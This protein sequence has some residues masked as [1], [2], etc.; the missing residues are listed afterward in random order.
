VLAFRPGITPTH[1]PDKTEILALLSAGVTT[2]IG[3]VNLSDETDVLEFAKVESGRLPFNIG[4]VGD[5]S[6]LNGRD[7][8]ADLDLL[9]RGIGHGLLAIVKE[10]L[11]ADLVIHCERL[12]VPLIPRAE[13]SRYSDIAKERSVL[14]NPMDTH[15]M[16][17]QLGLENRGVIRIGAVA[18]LVLFPTAGG[19]GAL[20]NEPSHVLVGG[21]IVYQDGVLRSLPV[22]QILRRN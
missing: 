12:R 1:M 4:F 11:P 2:L 6:G 17:R 19:S 14:D 9:L 5:G 8:S 3:S 20:L 10:S 18:D 22:G 7:P 21:N 15:A 13:L 16:F